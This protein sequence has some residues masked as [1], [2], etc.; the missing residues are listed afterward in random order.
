MPA[1]T[2]IARYAYLAVF[3]LSVVVSRV[4]HSQSD[5][6]ADT[7]SYDDGP[8]VFWTDE[9]HAVVISYIGGEFFR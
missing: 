2:N 1:P 6:V 5:S 7:V 8:H 4:T 3:I 9:S